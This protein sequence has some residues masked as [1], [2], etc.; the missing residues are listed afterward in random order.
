MSGPDGRPMTGRGLLRAMTH[1]CC[2][3]LAWK[4]GL[5]RLSAAHRPIG[6]LVEPASFE[7]IGK[8]YVAPFGSQLERTDRDPVATEAPGALP[9]GPEKMLD[10]RPAGRAVPCSTPELAVQVTSA[11]RVN[12]DAVCA[13][14]VPC[15]AKISAEVI[16]GLA[17]LLRGPRGVEAMTVGASRC[18]VDAVL[19]APRP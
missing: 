1:R 4:N 8:L 10:P 19:V 14:L 16:H 17:G 13:G 2:G 15:A 11:A 5:C 9:I 3:S 18:L 7:L 12:G 6:D